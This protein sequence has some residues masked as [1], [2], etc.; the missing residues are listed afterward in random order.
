MK[1]LQDILSNQHLNFYFVYGL[2]SLN[3]SNNE[4]SLFK[5]TD[6]ETVSQTDPFNFDI[7]YRN[8]FLYITNS[9]PTTVPN[10]RWKFKANATELDKSICLSVHWDQN[11]IRN[12]KKGNL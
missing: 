3:S 12:P 10:N 8:S 7:S 6:N 1:T 5:I 11:N 4:M 9:F 2:K